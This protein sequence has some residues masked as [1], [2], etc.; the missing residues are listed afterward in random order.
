MS[1]GA[2]IAVIIG[3]VVVVLVAAAAAWLVVQSRRL[4]ERFG[5]EYDRLVED[6]GRIEAEREL[7]AREKRHE[8]YELRM[9]EPGARE[10]YVREWRAVQEHFVDTPGD[11]VDEADSLLT[12]LMNERGYPTEGYEEQ[13]SVLSVE[14]GRML[15]HYRNAHAVQVRSAADEASTEDLRGALVEYRAVFDDLLANSGDGGEKA[16]TTS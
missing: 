6:R 15:E 9:L 12:R 5:P 10:Q 14:H 1:T 7:R 3:A 2:L 16:R 11:A 8:S 13:M 4:R